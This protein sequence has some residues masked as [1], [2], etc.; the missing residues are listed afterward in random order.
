MIRKFQ[1]E[2]IFLLTAQR[3]T[4]ILDKS[5]QRKQSWQVILK[6]LW[7][8]LMKSELLKFIQTLTLRVTLNM[9]LSSELRV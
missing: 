9:R 1:K 2:T 7:V 4:F 6:R 8:G 3:V 5:L